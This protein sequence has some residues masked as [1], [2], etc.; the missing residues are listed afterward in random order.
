MPD[1]LKKK[2]GALGEEIF[3]A[4]KKEAAANLLRAAG[5][6][7]VGEVGVEVVDEP[8]RTLP[9]AKKNLGGKNTPAK[10]KKLAPED[11]PLVMSEEEF[12]EECGEGLP[13]LE[14]DRNMLQKVL[15]AGK[16]E[17]EEIELDSLRGGEIVGMYKN[18]KMVFKKL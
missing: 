7:A 10:P 3:L 11:N 14:V 2:W 15:D 4:G 13:V 17:Y 18:Q 1:D 5:L 12:A 9:V 6:A 8:A 16:T